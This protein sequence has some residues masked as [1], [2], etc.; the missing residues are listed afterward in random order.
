MSKQASSAALMAGDRVARVYV[1]G[2]YHTPDQR[3]LLTEIINV[4]DGP[5]NVVSQFT[6]GNYGDWSISLP[7]GDTERRTAWI[8]GCDVVV[9][10]LN[11]MDKR[12]NNLF[13]EALMTKLAEIEL[14]LPGSKSSDAGHIF[15]Q[16]HAV[17][18]GQAVTLP[19][20]IDSPTMFE[21][22][23]AFAKGKKIV[24]LAHSSPMVD[25][26]IRACA[27]EIV[28][29]TGALLPAIRGLFSLA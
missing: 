1:S 4:L 10:Q 26:H 12:S 14:E 9:A 21:L 8:D 7:I 20:Y 17:H 23:I 18:W 6:H 28:R 24:G 2:P 19:T 25:L 27:H 16:L 5:T 3:A 29:S 13:T 11:P 15:T 22:G